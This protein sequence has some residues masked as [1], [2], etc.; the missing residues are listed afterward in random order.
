M[1]DSA[2]ATPVAAPGPAEQAEHL[3]QD[4]RQ[5][6]R[7][8]DLDA[9][10]ELYR[11]ALVDHPRPGHV[12]NDLGVALRADGKPRA[13]IACYHRAL[14]DDPEADDSWSNLGNACREIGDYDGA[15]DAL[16][17]A[18]ALAPDNTLYMFTLGVA[19]RETDRLDEA[20][21]LFEAL[22]AQEPD[23]AEN[24]FQLGVTRLQQ[25]DYRAGFA[26]YEGRLSVERLN[27]RKMDA[28]LWDGSDLEGRTLLVHAEQG[29][30]DMM[31]F[32]R[33]L[34]PLTERAGG[35]IVGEVHPPL[36]RLFQASFPDIDFVA[37]GEKAPLHHLRAPAPSLPHLLAI[38][39]QTLVP[40]MPY[41]CAGHEQ[42]GPALPNTGRPKI[43]LTWSGNKQQ[44]DR[45]CPFDLFMA[46]TEI[47]GADYYSLQRGD[48]VEDIA[49]HGMDMI[50]TDLGS[51]L[52]N[53]ADDAAVL[54]QLDLVITIDTSMCHLAGGMNVPCWTLL[55]DPADW[56]FGT[57]REDNPW[58]P[59]MRLF[60]G[61]ETDGWRPIIDRAK[62]ALEEFVATNGARVAR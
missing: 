5:T 19:L 36:L 8:G 12:F 31:Q 51:G 11:R 43:G 57:G 22:I 61:K 60:R 20:V 56:R 59:S 47:A 42:R 48:A 53:F 58:Y 23:D 16:R 14:A 6:H 15:A 45:S 3:Y 44:K 27:P 25:G 17:R 24:R 10:I 1:P 33:F 18:H 34:L 50:V 9:A 4:A 29:L 46:L 62:I 39:A 13:A 40:A 7:D 38:D 21:A 26:G 54:E 37:V 35:K 32:A 49:S 28:P 2:S 52:G 55:T 41:L 30:G